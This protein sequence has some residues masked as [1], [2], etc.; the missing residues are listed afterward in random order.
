MKIL[1]SAYAC[2]PNRGSEE[3]FGWNW[4]THL[5]QEGHEV[6]VATRPLAREA[7]ERELKRHPIA[8]LHFMYLDITERY[9]RFI[10]GL[11]GVY[12]HYFL[13]QRA[14][15]HHVKSF[16]ETHDIDLV[17]HVTWGSLIGGSWL[18][19]LD[20]PFVFGP[21]GG[22]Q[23]APKS[24][25]S[26]FPTHW[27]QEALRT[28]ITEY[29]LPKHPPT[30]KMLNHTDLLLATNSETLNVARSMGARKAELFLD[31]GL[32]RH[33]FAEHPKPGFS[34]KRM[35]ILWV[36]RLL[37]RKALRLSLEAV[38]K[39]TIPFTLTI[40]GDGPQ[41]VHL[42][43]WI[44]ELN[45]EGKVDWRGRVPW[46]EV[47]QAF[48][49]HEVF[50]FTSLR[51]SFGSQLLE[52]MGKGLAIVTLDHQGAHDFVPDE[53]GFRVPVT[54]PASTSDA[55]A[56]SLNRLYENPQKLRGMSEAGLEFARQHDWN[57][58]AAQMTKMYED[59][60]KNLPQVFSTR[61]MVGRTTGESSRVE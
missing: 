35:N 15:F 18:W 58:K 16:L 57:I 30:R 61:S 28:A 2:E 54:T 27:K 53:A 56:Q 14:A 40:L 42:H 49:E 36:G 8:N 24:F 20:K 10:K 50:L 23:V 6:W 44:K 3:G 19:R 46:D 25:K 31:T 51:D 48:E 29:I 34:K 5:A 33:Y 43:D 7:I 55:L 9:K 41:E 39:L 52:A 17:H 22:G 47:Q 21:V 37:E 13:W 32:P 59:V 38:A 11:F 60:V 45:L 12:A 4:S 26:Y 1:L